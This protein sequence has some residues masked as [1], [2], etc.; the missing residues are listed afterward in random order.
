MR[1]TFIIL[2]ILILS[3][4]GGVAQKVIFRPW[5]SYTA[6]YN[7]FKSSSIPEPLF[8]TTYTRGGNMGLIIEHPLKKYGRVFFKI[9]DFTIANSMRE[10][11]D[12]K[13][14]FLDPIFGSSAL[15]SE[16]GSIL[17]GIG[18]NTNSIQN[19]KSKSWYIG[20]CVNLGFQ[21][22][23]DTLGS[24]SG[25]YSSNL[26]IDDWKRTYQKKVFTSFS[27]SISHP[28]LNKRKKEIVE[29][30]ILF[31]HSFQTI[32]ENTLY[33]KYSG[34]RYGSSTEQHAIFTNKGQ[35]ILLS[36]SKSISF[37]KRKK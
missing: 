3:G 23:I 26:I 22:S 2:F 16:S 20:G 28:I 25:P 5:V 37:F 21:E 33:F 35:S 9:A 27:L 13:P 14:E 15:R 10:A 18:F 24:I 30:S 36:V 32:S 6:N 29:I 4:Q 1:N 17:L 11:N 7:H 34:P 31:N 12:K 19:I 8:S